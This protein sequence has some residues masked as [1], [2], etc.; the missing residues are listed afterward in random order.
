MPQGQGGQPGQGGQ[1]IFCQL[2]DSP[3]ETM[4]IH[5]TDNVRAWL[6]INPRARGHTMVVP[7]E[8]EEHPED[9]GEVLNEMFNVARIVGEKAKNGLG[10]EG[11]SMVMNDGEVAGQKVP[12]FYMIV[13][14]RF[15][16][17]Q[18]E[19]TPTGAIFPPIE[20]MDENDLQG[21]HDE[22]ADA[23]YNDFSS[24]HT[25]AYREEVRNKERDEEESEQ[26]G[27]FR[28]D[29]PAEFR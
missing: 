10:A 21:I 28:R 4:T 1:C 7:K 15:E 14:P 13:F 25:S 20:D 23:S 3:Q 9:L 5:E 29:D 16:G 26:E 24:S 18:N 27:S 11:Y 8:H 2:L 22:M 12:H 19:G 6:D 17:E